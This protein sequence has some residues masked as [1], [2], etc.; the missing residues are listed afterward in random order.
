MSYEIKNL[1]IEPNSPEELGLE[2]IIARD[3]VSPEEAIRGLLRNASPK[4]TPAQRM[5]GLLSKDAELVDEIVELSR[6]GR[7]TPSTRNIGL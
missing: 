1:H 3:H 4:R 5:I 2:A 6:E 7:Q